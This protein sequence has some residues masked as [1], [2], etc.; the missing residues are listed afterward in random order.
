MF[1]ILLSALSFLSLIAT[2]LLLWQSHTLPAHFPHGATGWMVAWFGVF[3][4]PTITATLLTG[5]F[6]LAVTS[7]CVTEL[8]LGFLLSV[9]SAL[10]SL[11]CLLGFLGN[12]YPAISEILEKWSR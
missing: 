9:F 8:L 11:L 3:E 6:L 7:A 5:S 4:N 1:R 2:G 10:V 12:H